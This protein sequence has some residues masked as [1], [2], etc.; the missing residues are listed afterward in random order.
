MTWISPE[1]RSEI[2]SRSDI[3]DI[4]G[5]YVSLKRAG[6]TYKGLCPFHNEKTPSFSVNPNLQIYKCF[7]C[8]NTGN[9]VTFL[10]EY[11]NMSYVEALEYLAEK[12]GITIV[13]ATPSKTDKEK[14]DR[15]NA[16]FEIN[17]IAAGHYFNMLKSQEG[18]VGY[19]YLKN[20]G[21]SDE[22]IIHFGLGFSGKG[23]NRLY[24]MLKDKGYDDALITESKLFKKDGSKMYEIFWNRVMFPILDKSNHVIGFGGRVMSDVKPKYLNSIENEIFSK[25]KNLYALNFARKSRSKFIILCEGY[26]DVIALHQAGF[27]SAVASLG[28]ALTPDQVREIKRYADDIYLTYDSDEAGKTAA[29]RAIPMLR[30]GNVTPRI[31]DL[32]PY[33]DPDELI[34][35]KGKEEFQMRIDNAQNG[36]AFECEYL[37]R[38]INMDD[39]DSRASFIKRIAALIADINDEVI[40][41]SYIQFACSKY[42]IDEGVLKNDV[43]NLRQKSAGM[44][45]KDDLIQDVHY[46]KKYE[47]ES[48]LNQAYALVLSWLLNDPGYYEKI[49]KWIE[50]EAF[51]DKE[52]HEVA[53]KIYAQ[54]DE[55]KLNPSFIISSYENAEEQK[56]VSAMLTTDFDFE[57]PKEDK[58]KSLAEMITL[59]LKH[60]VKVKM[61][62]VSRKG[63]MSQVVK[64]ADLK[65]K[66]EKPGYVVID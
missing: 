27:D 29:M 31:L 66:L 8:N 5:N 32:S 36:F 54:L 64:L 48:G 17:K 50:P 46:G 58:D 43:R 30:R 40:G 41:E 9:V 63:D 25:G 15:K 18:S 1:Q 21:L 26:M 42:H 14:I 62:E 33:K 7:G 56:R 49:K 34:K 39:P 23:G 6:S 55:G 16:L 22:T 65:R 12:A 52:Y 51:I 38:G 19:S 57:L 45:K 61:E 53:L 20:R 3:V 11:E 47:K 60:Y 35:A 2:L 59:I 10:M 28:T 4:I 37:K 44:I 24:R 13:S